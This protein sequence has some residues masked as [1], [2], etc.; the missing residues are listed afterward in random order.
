MTLRVLHVLDHSSPLHS[1]Y[2]FRTL[3]ILREQQ[4]LGWQ[5]VQ[6]TT[7]KQG[8]GTALQEEASGLLFQR[9]PS[10][11]GAGLLHQ[12]LLTAR[13]L[14]TV[15][16]DTRPHLIHAHSPVLTALPSLWV[17]RSLQLPVVYEMRASWEDAAV[18]HGS[19]HEHSL[20]YRTSR[21]LETFVLRH[22]C[23]VTTIC[24][25]LRVEIAARGVAPARI[26]VIPNAVDAEAFA[27][28]QEPDAA[29]R[30]RL[31]LDGALVLGF[32]GSFYA[33]EGLHL[34]IDAAARLRLQHPQLRVLLVGG[35][36]QEDA[37]RAQVAAQGLQEV[38]L[39]AGRVDHARMPAY[40][41][42]M[43]VLAYPRLPMRLTELVTPLKPLEAMALGK[44]LVASDV[45]GHRELV[46]HGVT[47][48]LFRA[49]DGAALEE[50]IAT[51]LAHRQHWPWMREQAR[52]FVEQE[53]TWAHSVARYRA[54]YQRAL[55]TR[56]HTGPLPI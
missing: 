56:H 31:G 33:Y 47:G 9:T 6:L 45:G 17:G 54:V 50:S 11:V 22:A 44:L 52:R 18:D 5:T 39:F 30:H 20:R 4:R 35:G 8:P 7:P 27:F 10:P 37:L 51:L 43:D 34:L 15:V 55:Q 53:R 21:A 1:G 13:R 41:S 46:R 23:E 29:L 2:S 42:L 16:Q 24:E 32:A 12:M 25:G 3:S 19:T 49:G 48:M 38:V 36:F 14:R 28:G 40:Y 26:T